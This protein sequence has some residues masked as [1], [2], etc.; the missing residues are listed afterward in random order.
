MKKILPLISLVCVLYIQ[1]IAQETVQWR[2]AGR[3]GIY[4]ETN[5]L[6]KWPEAGPQLLWH[7]DGLGEGHASPAVTGNRVYT[8]GILEGIGYL[9]CFDLAG[10]QLWKVAYGEEWTESWP[11]VRST[12][13]VSNG[14]IYQLSGF[15]KLVCR[16]AENGD[17]IWSVDVLKDYQGP[18]IKWGVTENLLID[19]NKLFCTVGGTEANVIALNPN[20][21]SLIWKSKGK[22][23]VSAYGSPALIKLAKKHILVAQTA[24]SIL[25]IDTDN[26]ALLWSHDQPNKY[27]VHANTPLYHDGYLYCVSG[28]GKGGVMLKVSDDGSSVQEVWRNTNIDN[29]MGGFVLV[30]GKIFGSDD[31]G[32]AWY[33]LDWKTGTNMYSEKITGRGNIIFADGMLYLYGDNGEVVLA[34]PL[35][36]SFKKISAFQVPFGADQHWA[37]LVIGNGRLYVRHGSSLMVYDI[38][39]K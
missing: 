6:K 16:N 12:P 9:F 8:A 26:G 38:R 21:G 5:L 19:G 11:G 13:L 18:N 4:S 24:N 39:S 29:K 32:K 37:H 1:T 10:K 3:D 30:N 22:G 20:T 25:G 23:E 36:N 35:A 28:Y 33:C 31:A 34:E 27:S 7:F 17:F 15:G 2:G 14:K